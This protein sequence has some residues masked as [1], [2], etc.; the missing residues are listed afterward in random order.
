MGG[1]LDRP[2]RAQPAA[3]PREATSDVWRVNNLSNQSIAW[4]MGRRWR[5]DQSRPPTP[6]SLDRSINRVT[7]LN[8]SMHRAAKG[9]SKVESE[10]AARRR[11]RRARVRR[12]SGVGSTR[13]GVPSTN[14][15]KNLRRGC[16]LS[17]TTDRLMTTAH[18]HARQC[19]PFKPQAQY[20]ARGG[21]GRPALDAAGGAWGWWWWQPAL[22][23]VR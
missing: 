6:R 14:R 11:A 21:R 18:T 7:E 22:L 16:P 23:R 1:G 2:D 15:K 19:Q 13:P 9:A 12:A 10:K 5:I 20:A 8:R 4:A 3:Q 17:T